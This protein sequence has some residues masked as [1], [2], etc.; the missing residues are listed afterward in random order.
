MADQQPFEEPIRRAFEANL[1]YYEALGQ[2]TQDYFR[3]L[4]GIV[5]EIPIR[6]PGFGTATVSPG[7]GAAPRPAN[8]TA[9]AAAAAAT[10]VLEGEAGAEA[11]GVFMVENRLSRTVSTAVVTSAFADPSGRAHHPRL[12]VIP[13]VVTLE[14]GGRSLVQIFA[15]VGGELEADVPYRGEVSVPGLSDHSIPVV[16]RRKA[17]RSEPVAQKA[18]P[19]KKKGTTGKAAKKSRRKAPRRE[20]GG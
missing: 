7:A 10:L 9:P 19:Q 6:I 11:Q 12:R 14:P 1:R 15:E 16:L 20:P 18:P 17:V 8:M 4:F 3:S 5:R 13:S 2:V